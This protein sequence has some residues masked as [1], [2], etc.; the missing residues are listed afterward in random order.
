MSRIA[1]IGIDPGIY[2]A[3]ARYTIDDED[4]DWCALEVE[5]MP[6]NE[7]RRGKTL[8]KWVDPNLVA[9]V[10]SAYEKETAFVQLEAVGASPQMGVTSSF[11]FGRSFGVVEGVV[12][13][14]EIPIKYVQPS[15]WKRAVGIKLRASKDESRMVASQIWPEWSHLWPL[16]KDDGKAEAMLLAYYGAITHG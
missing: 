16:K 1:Y 11:S 9:T 8:K 13:G 12:A 6:V 14:M 10:I 4:P 5:P 15:T 2:G 3:I 7:I